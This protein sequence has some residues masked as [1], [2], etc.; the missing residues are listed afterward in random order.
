MSCPIHHCN[1]LRHCHAA[2]SCTELSWQHPVDTNV[3]RNKQSTYRSL[4]MYRAR[5]VRICINK[6][7]QETMAVYSVAKYSHFHDN[8]EVSEPASVLQTREPLRGSRRETECCEIVKTVPNSMDVGYVQEGQS[9]SRIVDNNLGAF[10]LKGS[11]CTYMY[12][13]TKHLTWVSYTTSVCIVNVGC[14]QDH[15]TTCS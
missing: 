6:T 8:T 2:V 5:A 12:K 15:F 3:L 9:G 11:G 1:E 14:D 4:Y 7:S 10:A 13:K